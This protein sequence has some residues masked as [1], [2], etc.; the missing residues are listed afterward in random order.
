MSEQFK[1]NFIYYGSNNSAFFKAS[2]LHVQNNTKN[3]SPMN[4]PTIHYPSHSLC[5]QDRTELHKGWIIQL[6]I[7]RLAGYTAGIQMLAHYISD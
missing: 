5:G 4:H 3:E 7:E 2:S 1:D 6:C